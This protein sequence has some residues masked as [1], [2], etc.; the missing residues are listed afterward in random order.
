MEPLTEQRPQPGPIVYGFLRMASPT[1]SRRRA[2]SDTLVHYCDRHEL[3]LG[4]VFTERHTDECM[5]PAFT[6]LLDALVMPGTYGVV[7]PAAIHLGP[8]AIGD[9]RRHQLAR[10][11]TR[12]M[13][14]RVHRNARS[15]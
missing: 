5:S 6:G 3:T 7:V 1:D 10:A 8:P 2:L 11:G 15:L 12:L 9:E 13:V 4:G 14:V